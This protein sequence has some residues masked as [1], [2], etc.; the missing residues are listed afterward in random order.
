MY[1]LVNFLDLHPFLRHLLFSN[2]SFMFIVFIIFVSFPVHFCDDIYLVF[3]LYI[4]FVLYFVIIIKIT[5]LIR[6]R[7]IFLSISLD[8]H[9]DIS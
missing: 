9:I 3:I 1:F 5:N 7:C 6:F 4:N 2:L 8:L